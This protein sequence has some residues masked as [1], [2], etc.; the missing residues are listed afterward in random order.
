MVLGTATNR[1]TVT[2]PD[3]L[4]WFSLQANSSVP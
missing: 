1:I 2:L 3:G 4:K